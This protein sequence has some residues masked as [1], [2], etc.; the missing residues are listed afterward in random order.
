MELHAQKIASSHPLVRELLERLGEHLGEVREERPNR[1]YCAI[2][3]GDN[4]AVARVLYC[5]MGARLATIS[6]VD[7]RDAIELNYHF[8][9]DAQHCVVTFKTRAPKP[10]PHVESIAPLIAGA[11]WI[12]RE[13]NDLIGCRF[14]HHPGL[15][16]LILADDW[17]EGVHPLSREYEQ[18]ARER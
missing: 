9:C 8:C 2:A 5:E 12:E 18:W 4:A 14:D 6:A 13:I 11:N 16:R 10:D 17:P 1:I 7:L 3:P 15:E